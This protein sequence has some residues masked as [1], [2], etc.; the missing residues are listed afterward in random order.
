MRVPLKSWLEQLDNVLNIESLIPLPAKIFYI[1]TTD[2]VE[3]LL[4]P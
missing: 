1:A 2:I 4:L 3:H